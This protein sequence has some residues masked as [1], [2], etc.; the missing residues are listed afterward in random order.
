MAFQSL[1]WTECVRAIYTRFQSEFGI[2]LSF[3]DFEKKLRR[4]IGSG[5]SL[6]TRKLA[7]A[8]V[9]AIT[10]AESIAKLLKIVLG[11]S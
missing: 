10:V 2:Q 1:D 4:S 8:T 7:K 5:G 6:D 9:S 3:E 11:G